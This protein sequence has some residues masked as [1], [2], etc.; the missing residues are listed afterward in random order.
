M[1]NATYLEASARTA[2]AQFHDDKV[3]PAMI[4]MALAQAV[5][6]GNML[7]AIKKGIYYGKSLPED[8]PT[9]EVH[10]E[11]SAINP[12]AIDQDILH[13]ALGV[14]T[15][16]TEMLEAILEAMKGNGFDK[17]NAAEELGDAEWYM[18]MMYRALGETPENVKSVNIEKL[19]HRYP[20]KFTSFNAIDRDLDTERNILEDGHS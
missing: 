3:T 1:D 8:H 10:A 4:E 15:E 12:R 13:A 11:K 7:D 20:D 6:T 9:L 14:Y 2:S 19:R 17:V 18:A 16:A 5:E